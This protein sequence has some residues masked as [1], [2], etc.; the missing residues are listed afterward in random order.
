MIYCPKS[1]SIIDQICTVMYHYRVVM[2]KD[3]KRIYLGKQEYKKLIDWIE[4]NCFYITYKTGNNKEP[5]IMG[6]K[7]YEVNVENHCMVS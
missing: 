6:C 7:V 1:I 5:T 3:P 2:E 4:E